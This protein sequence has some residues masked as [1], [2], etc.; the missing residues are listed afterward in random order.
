MI[1]VINGPLIE[2]GESLSNAV[3]CRGGQLVRITMPENWDDA[4][5]TFEFSSDGLFFNGIFDL[6]GFAVS[7]KH[8]VKGS[9]VIVP[10]DF[11]RAIAFM[12][13]R[14]GTRGNPV[15]QSEGRYFAVAVIKPPE[16]EAPARSGAKRK[17][18]A[19]KVAKKKTRR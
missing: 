7:I 5:L 19:K 15:P 2:A 3:D 8:V 11:G 17:P 10:H 1:E 6:E 4:P 12:K 9:G 18:P 14:S 13:F 16:E